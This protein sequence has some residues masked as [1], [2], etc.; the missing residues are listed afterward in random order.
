MC[1]YTVKFPCKV[2]SGSSGFEHTTLYNLKWS[3][4]SEI[5]CYVEADLKLRNIKWEFHCIWYFSHEE[6]NFVGLV[7][8]L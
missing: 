1:N 5:E 3:G 6:L 8:S 4:I 2:S 7:G